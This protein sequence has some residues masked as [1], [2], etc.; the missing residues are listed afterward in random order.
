[1]ISRFL[2]AA[3]VALGPL[4]LTAHEQP[5][6]LTPSPTGLESLDVDTLG[7]D[8]PDDELEAIVSAI[9]SA[10]AISTAAHKL[11]SP[12]YG[13]H[14]RR[15]AHAKT[16]GCVRAEFEINGD[17]PS[18]FQHSIFSEPGRSYRA[19]I[20]FSNGDMQVQPDGH[21]DARGMAIKVMDTGG[22][23]IAPE[24]PQGESANQDFIMT[25][26]P[27][28]FNRNIF[29]YAENMQHLAKM[30][31]SA[32]FFSLWPPRLHPKE[33]WR[34]YQTVSSTIDTPLAEQYFS[35][36]PYRLGKSAIKFSTRPCAGSDFTDARANTQRGDNYLTEQ[37]AQVLDSKSACFDF[38]L[39]PR[40]SGA[41]ES[42]M[43]LDDGTAIWKES[44]SP[45]IPVARVYIP[46][47]DFASEGQDAF[48]ENISM[49]PWRGVG[50]WEPLGSLNRARR[51]VY[52]AVS[53]FRHR[54][55]DTHYQEP[56]NW[57]IPKPGAPCPGSQGLNIRKPRW[58]L[59]RCF[60][61]HFRPKNGSE[62][63]SQ[64]GGYGM[65]TRSLDDT[66][67]DARATAT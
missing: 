18:R 14:Y 9:Q 25:N 5:Q 19:W 64:C 3:G 38:L 20:R 34:A 63:S 41:A 58:P 67:G 21:G 27:A 53:D 10:R 39:Q 29:D 50:E 26:T 1:M 36:L 46:P 61:Q 4:T 59:P 66:T 55:N 37:M 65:D 6:A 43:P 40:A 60:D 11:N 32:W 33:M 47:Q 51:L 31:R 23:P 35:M 30:D 12:R 2:L 44:M 17:I 48:C 13:N 22:A 45:F 42:E 56:E 54:K 8:I 7:M 16:T 24:L 28:F 57:C 49:N 52:H 15:D 62:V